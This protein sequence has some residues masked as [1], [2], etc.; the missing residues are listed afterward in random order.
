MKLVEF[1]KE[2]LIVH[3][4]MGSA[5]RYKDLKRV[6]GLSDAWLSKK[7]QELL[8]VGMV[9]LR[10]GHYSLNVKRFQEALRGEKTFIARLVAQELVRRMDSDVLAVVLFGSL[11][12]NSRGEGD[13]DLLIVTPHEDFDPLMVSVEMLRKFGVAVDIVHVTLREFL[14]WLYDKPP[15]L[16]GVLSG[17]EIL[18]DRGYIKDFLELLKIEIAKEWVYVKEDK[19]WVR[20]E[21]LP[22]MLKHA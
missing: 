11:V 22:L 1:T 7:L 5:L 17:F 14:A 18:F 8:R 6:T 16:F 10:D 3:A 20:R 2:G 4:L 9:V 12:Q 15:I 21:L 19:L 13:I